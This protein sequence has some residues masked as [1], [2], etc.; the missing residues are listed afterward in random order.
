MLTRLFVLNLCSTV[1]FAM[2]PLH[3]RVPIVCVLSL[4]WNTYFS[5]I[6][7]LR[8]VD[9]PWEKT[10]PLSRDDI[11]DDVAVVGVKSETTVVA[12]A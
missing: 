1:N 10:L 11:R 12:P 2:A 6:T 3:L 8:H 9:A 7:S 5:Y 4:L